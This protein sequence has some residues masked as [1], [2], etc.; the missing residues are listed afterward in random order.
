MKKPL[1]F[2]FLLWG[3]STGVQQRDANFHSEY[4]RLFHDARGKAFAISS[5]GQLT[6]LA[7]QEMLQQG[8]NIFDAFA[9]MSFAIS[10]ERPQS[11]GIGG[12]GFALVHHVDGKK[13][14]AVDFR[15]K[16][17]LK[18][19]QKMFVQKDQKE[20]LPSQE[21]VLAGGVPG[22][23]AGVYEIH[24]KYGDLPWKEVLKPAI[25]MASEG[26]KISSA[27]AQAIEKKVDL[28]KRFPASSKVFLKGDGTP[29]RAGDLLIQRDLAETLKKIQLKGRD[30]FYEGEVAK[31][32][33]GH[34]EKWG[35]FIS[36]ADLRRYNVKWRQPVTGS[37]KGNT[38]ASMPP[39]SSGG[40]HILQILNMLEKDDLKSHGPYHP[41]TIHMV[42]QAMQTAFVDRAKYLGDT[43]F[44]PVPKGGL[45]SKKYAEELREKFDTEVARSKSDLRAGNPWAYESSET[46]HFSL[47]DAE[48][49]A[50]AS[51][52]T[53]NGLFGS[54]MVI[55]GTG[56]LLNNEMDD[57]ATSVG[58]S[59]LFGAVGG[60]QNL[61]EPEKR[62][63]SSMSPTFVFNKEGEVE[64]ALGSP[65]GTRILTCV[66]QVLLNRLEF[67][68]DY[69]DAVSSVRYHHQWSPDEIRFD[70]PGFDPGTEK[71]LKAM[72]YT[73]NRQ[74]LGCRVQLTAREGK[75]LRAISDPRST[76]RAL[77][78]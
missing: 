36:R 46:T 31:A 66:T 29:M 23:V 70:A 63:L 69:F 61:I 37:F 3:C 12:G 44:S 54:G 6:S 38:I 43:D 41:Y 11:T 45:I 55:E 27:L 49:N 15:E 57:F 39:P 74:D 9:A 72:G 56:I 71:K 25:K 42:S 67:N 8:G 47:M 21:G 22:L 77:A 48:G 68:K 18:A 40:I 33:T 34:Q 16:A 4:D 78:Y 30:G 7:G 2:L 53:I 64:I 28:L 19:F 24:K 62:P 52:Q 10:V 14:E 75:K 58:A 17:P 1:I 59:N 76:G 20:S 26:I 65:A 51:T 73:L 50:I 35:G 32:I 5:G 13:T 60:E